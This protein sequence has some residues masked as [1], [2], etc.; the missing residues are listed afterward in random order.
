MA[1]VVDFADRAALIK[2]LAQGMSEVGYDL[3]DDDVSVEP[4][5]RDERIGWNTHIVCIRNKKLKSGVWYFGKAMGPNYYGA[6]GW[7]DGPV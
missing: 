2:I 3:H 6:H 7:T 5:A 4:Y 1:E